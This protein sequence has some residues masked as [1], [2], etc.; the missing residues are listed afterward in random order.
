M[1][2]LDRVDSAVPDHW[3]L[4]RRPAGRSFSP[5]ACALHPDYSSS[6]SD[7]NHPLDLATDS[8]LVADLFRKFLDQH[9]LWITSFGHPLICHSH[10]STWLRLALCYSAAYCPG[11]HIWPH[12]GPTLCNFYG[13]KHCRNISACTLAYSQLRNAQHLLHLCGYAPA[14]L[15]SRISHNGPR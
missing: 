8:E 15:E 7:W 4:S 13:R 1:G 10:D 9:L 12:F 3:L 14:R 11:R 6:I 5:P 2:E